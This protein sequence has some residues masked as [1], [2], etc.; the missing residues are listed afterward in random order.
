MKY[1]IPIDRSSI[2]PNPHYPNLHSYQTHPTIYRKTVTNIYEGYNIKNMKLVSTEEIIEEIQGREVIKSLGVPPHY[3]YSHLPTMVQCEYCNAH[4]N[5]EDLEYDCEDL[6]SGWTET[7]CP[8]CGGWECCEI[9][10]EKLS[11]EILKGIY[12][13]N[14]QS[15]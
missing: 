5:H 15:S 3:F 10:Y 11:E 2:K 7:K 8:K 14:K 1:L 9:E 13:S 6:D 12:E 4:F